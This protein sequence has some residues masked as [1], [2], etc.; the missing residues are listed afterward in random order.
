LL[1]TSFCGSTLLARML[2]VP[3]RAF[4]YKEPQAL[5]HLAQLKGSPS[6]YFRDDDKWQL[7]IDFVLGQLRQRWS[8]NEPSII[9]P[10]NWVNSILPDLA[11]ATGGLKAVMLSIGAAD[12]LAAVFRGGGERVRFTYS[13]LTHLQPSLPEYTDLIASVLAAELDTVQMFARMTLIAHAMQL[14]AFSQLASL[15]PADDFGHCSYNG[16]L[17]DSETLSQR[18]A[19][20][21]ELD[22]SLSELK[23]SIESNVRRHSKVSDRDY[24]QRQAEQVNREVN[25]AYFDSFLDALYWGSR[26]LQSA[27]L[28]VSNAVNS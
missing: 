16:L 9:K 12:F 26:H 4:C 5:I 17:R 20:T 22:L 13:L 1:H 3:G 15:L 27:C 2:D 14:R 7:L 11:A 25:S 24:D 8:H 18:A 6:D 28:E 10:S 21:L 23:S 19:K